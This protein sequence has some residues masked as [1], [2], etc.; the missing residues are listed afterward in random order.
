VL[1]AIRN[2]PNGY[3]VTSASPFPDERTA[4]HF[5]EEGYYSCNVFH[6]HEYIHRE[7]GRFFDIVDVRTRDHQS[8]CVVL[9]SY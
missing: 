1:T 4:F 6:P 2:S 5:T 8:Q 3:D 7:W 9:M